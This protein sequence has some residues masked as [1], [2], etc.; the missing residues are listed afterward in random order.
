MNQYIPKVLIVS[1]TA[2]EKDYCLKEWARMVKSFTY[3]AYDVLMIDNSVDV[4][5]IK[6]LLHEGIEAYH[7]P[8][9]EKPP[10]QWL[11][12][13]QNI[14]RQEFIKRGY[15][16]MF[17]LESDVFLPEDIIEYM[18]AF[19]H[20][21]HNIPYF[22]SLSKYNGRPSLCMQVSYVDND[23]R[24]SSIVPSP[25]LSPYLW[26]GEITESKQYKVAPNTYVTHTGIGCTLIN[27]SVVEMIPFRVDLESD[28]KRGTMTFSDTFF[29]LDLNKKGVPN[30][31]N[32]QF[33][34]QHR[35]A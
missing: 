32:R 14:L 3:P 33:I 34:A 31:I 11:C 24:S 26:D 1:P 27:R 7:Y 20:P 4:R 22:V 16:Y 13:C 21:V 5:H 28:R 29:H 35:K 2:S 9:G 18:L 6:R 19:K 30:Y 12:D 17:M 15:D 10:Q 25:D 8:R 23:A